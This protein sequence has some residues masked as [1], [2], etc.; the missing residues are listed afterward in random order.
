MTFVVVELLSVLLREDE[1]RTRPRTPLKGE[2]NGD[3]REQGKRE[4]TAISRGRCDLDFPRCKAPSLPASLAWR[5]AGKLRRGRS[6]ETEGDQRSARSWAAGSRGHWTSTRLHRAQTASKFD[7]PP[8]A[9]ESAGWC[10]R[11]QMAWACMAPRTV[12][13]LRE[14][15]RPVEEVERAVILGAAPG[16]LTLSVD[17]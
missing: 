15:R 14:A 6:F 17:I 16:S 13:E 10:R 12:R 9:S 7:R 1:M 2:Q 8:D 5:S 4:L 11:C 3:G